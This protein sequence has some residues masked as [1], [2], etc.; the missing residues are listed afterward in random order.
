MSPL[1]SLHLHSIG[2]AACVGIVKSLVIYTG[3]AASVSLVKSLVPS[4]STRP[5]SQL[6]PNSQLNPPSQLV[7]S[8]STKYFPPICFHWIFSTKYFSAT[9]FQWIF[10]TKKFPSK[11]V[12]QRNSSK[13]VPNLKIRYL[14]SLLGL[15]SLILK[16]TLV[17]NY[18][19][20]TLWKTSPNQHGWNSERISRGGVVIIDPKNYVADVFLF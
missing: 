18:Y 3:I 8:H 10:S 20:M 14:H 13:S 19:W 16:A 1:I 15:I 11:I 4:Q 17:W 12:H 6:V 7:P 2:I 9:I 5:P